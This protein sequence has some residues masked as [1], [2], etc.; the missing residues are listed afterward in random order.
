MIS[1]STIMRLKFLGSRTG[2]L[3]SGALVTLV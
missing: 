3:G 2:A 1:T